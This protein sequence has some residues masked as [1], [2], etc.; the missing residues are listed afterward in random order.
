MLD[1]TTD[2]VR[3]PGRG[4]RHG[5]VGGTR[6][7]R[8]F[9]PGASTRGFLPLDAVDDVRFLPLDASNDAPLAYRGAAGYWIGTGGSTGAIEPGSPSRSASWR[10]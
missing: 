8:I 1:A 10:G 5:A 6:T 7:L 2:T 9:S 4:P 3:C